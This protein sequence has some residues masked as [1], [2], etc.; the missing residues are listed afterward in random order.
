MLLWTQNAKIEA[1]TLD[2]CRQY[3][4]HG[5]AHLTGADNRSALREPVGTGDFRSTRSDY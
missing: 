4:S 3:W 2:M 5:Y 1:L